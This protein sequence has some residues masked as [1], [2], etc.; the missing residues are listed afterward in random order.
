VKTIASGS[1][2]E[3][4]VLQ[5][6]EL[7]GVEVRSSEFHEC[8]FDG[9]TLCE[10]VLRACR[11]VECVFERCDLSLVRL[12]GSA[13]SACHFENSKIIGVNWTEASWPATRLWPPVSFARCVL[14]HSTFLG[15]DLTGVRITECTALDVDL[16]EANL[17]GAC[18]DGTDLTGSQFGRTD[19]TDA[20]LRSAKG[21]RIDPRENTLRG[22]HFSLP[23]AI[24][25]LEGLDIDLTGWET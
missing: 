23:E 15:L 5:G 7:G 16:R 24:S 22:A 14:N 2:Y 6:I 1:R 12:P 21:Y 20:D 17:T 3:D 9:G 18:F 8:R 4:E 10:S 13:F 11:F 19:L 25:L